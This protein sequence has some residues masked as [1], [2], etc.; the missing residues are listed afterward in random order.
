MGA[1]WWEEG[2]GG[3]QGEGCCGE[4]RLVVRLWAGME[5]ERLLL[6]ALGRGGL[7]T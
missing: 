5:G 4:V 3:K 2:W 6:T 1:G 7:E